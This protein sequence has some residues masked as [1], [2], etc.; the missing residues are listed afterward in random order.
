MYCQPTLPRTVL[1]DGQRTAGSFPW[2]TPA[3][4][5]W[6]AFPSCLGADERLGIQAIHVKS[7]DRESR[8]C[9]SAVPGSAGDNF[10]PADRAP[11]A[12]EHEEP[13]VQQIGGIGYGVLGGDPLVVQI[14]TA[15]GDDAPGVRLA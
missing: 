12:P 4:D 8:T 5:A 6:P 14:G 7:R 2:L 3:P 1:M 11:A 10:R 13:P 15:L 9:R